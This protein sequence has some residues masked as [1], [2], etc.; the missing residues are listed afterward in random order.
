MLCT[1]QILL[2]LL[3]AVICPAAVSAAQLTVS[4]FERPPYY[5][6]TKTGAAGGFLVEKTRQILHQADIEARFISLQPNKIIFVLK[7]ATMPHCSIGWFKNP[8][9]EKLAKFTH[10]IYQNRPQVLLTTQQNAA[11][12]KRHHSLEDIFADTTLIMARM[13]SFS[14]GAYVDQLMQRHAPASSFFS[15]S[16]KALL[17]ALNNGSATY[18]L[19]APEEV[20]GLIASTD[21]P[22]SSFV[23]LTLPEIPHG[24]YRYLMCGEAVSDTL[25]K[26]LNTA[27]DKLSTAIGNKPSD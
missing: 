4:Y 24:N 11:K 15:R 23:Q 20:D 7:H 12:V 19:I 2:W 3:F 13:S 22:R 14:Y 21:L 10:P 6:T 5:L 25:I 18:M 26:R 17:Q 1:R 8:T 9:R 27:I 16:Q